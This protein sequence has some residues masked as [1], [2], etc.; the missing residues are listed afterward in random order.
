M[1][2]GSLHTDGGGRQLQAGRFHPRVWFVL[3][4]HMWSLF[5]EVRLTRTHNQPYEKWI[6]QAADL[7]STLF[8]LNRRYRNDRKPMIW[9][10]PFVKDAE[11]RCDAE[12]SVWEGLCMWV[13]YESAGKYVRCCSS[14][15]Y[16][17]CQSFTAGCCR[18]KQD[19]FFCP[20][21]RFMLQA[22]TQWLSV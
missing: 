6:S 15:L 3:N 17:T 20:R 12:R 8:T 14:D 19:D 18:K 4:G 5:W 21:L 2:H 1:F 22:L 10:S 13:R 16:I 11:Y 9:L 7:S